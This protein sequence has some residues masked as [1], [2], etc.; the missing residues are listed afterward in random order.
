MAVA[1][2]AFSSVAEGTGTLSWT[3]TPVGTPRAVRVDIV[4][5]GGTNGVSSVTYGGVALELVAA[6]AKTSGEAGTVVT[7]FLGKNIPAGA[8]T[9]SVTVSD[10]VAKRAGAIT[11]T[12]AGNTCWTAADVSVGS[13]S[14][15]NPTS[16]L[17][18]LG[19]T[20]FV[21]IALHSGMNAV[22]GITPSTGWTSR[23]EHDFGNQ[24]AAWYTYNTISTA[25]VACGWT[26]TADDAV[27]V[28]LA[29]TEAPIAADS[30]AV[31]LT[32]TASVVVV[33]DSRA[34]PILITDTASIAVILSASD[35]CVVQVSSETPLINATA[36]ASDATAVQLSEVGAA[37]FTSTF[38]LSVTDSLAV[39]ASEGSQLVQSSLSVLDT[40][41]AG[42]TDAH[43]IVLTETGALVVEGHDTA[44]VQATESIADLTVFVPGT[45]QN[46]VVSDSLK[47]QLN[48]SGLA[49]AVI[50]TI[51]VGV[52]ESS[53]TTAVFAVTD[54]TAVQASES[55]TLATDTFFIPTASDTVLAGLTESASVLAYTILTVSDT[56][57]VQAPEDVPDTATVITASDTILAGLSEPD[58]QQTFL[59]LFDTCAAQMASEVLQISGLLNFSIADST[60]VQV[61]DAA[62]LTA[63]TVGASES[64]RVQASEV[65]TNSASVSAI[66]STRAALTE[67]LSMFRDITTTDTS[68]VRASEVSAP[69]FAD[70]VDLSTT[71]SCVVQA[72]ETVSEL[73]SFLL[74]LT[75]TD[76]LVVQAVDSSTEQAVTLSA[77]DAC[78]AAASELVDIVTNLTATDSLL[79]G[80][81]EAGLAIPIV[82]V[83]VSTFA[84]DTILGFTDTAQLTEQDLFTTDDHALQ[85]SEETAIAN[86]QFSAE[87]VATLLLESVLLDLSNT[88]TETQACGLIESASISVVQDASDTNTVACDEES[89]MQPGYYFDDECG[90]TCDEQAEDLAVE[91]ASPETWN[92][93]TNVEHKLEFAHPGRYRITSNWEW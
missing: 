74:Q 15:A 86:T 62:S 53:Q 14:L 10:A 89:T 83:N 25:N 37:L 48:G 22:T 66:D 32:E 81:T 93:N 12:A 11:L 31:Q 5:N 73:I 87:T 46:F 50:E 7:Y 35:T 16:T 52:N 44:T 30:T 47:V 21:S 79:V 27:M 71:D 59:G 58:D 36:L 1:F 41:L 24:T 84:G 55:T 63:V 2:D 54:T 19:K 68:A 34:L 39:L 20:S 29:I 72:N 60:A 51:G 85:V 17:N 90:V 28:A 13:D 42:L 64:V 23:L 9:V 61:A 69:I 38:S 82:S 6:N 78:A 45:T 56:A 3:H 92:G 18:L 43:A 4:E 67:A 33:F 26:Q 88:L 49:Q 75:A 76:S 80:M 77:N 8:Q 65:L 40:L 57:K 70:F 91:N